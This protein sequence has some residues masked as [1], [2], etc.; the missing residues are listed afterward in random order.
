MITHLELKNFTAFTELTIDFS[1][2]INVIIGENGNGKTQLLKSVYALCAGG[3]ATGFQHWRRACVN[4]YSQTGSASH[5]A[6]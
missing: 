4:P 2:K 6:G 3:G 1:P 5:A